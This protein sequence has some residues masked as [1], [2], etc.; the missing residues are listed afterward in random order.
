M[1]DALCLPIVTLN[2]DR[3]YNLFKINLKKGCLG[4]ALSSDI[5]VIEAFELPLKEEPKKKYCH[6]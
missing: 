1:S 6:L 4:L 3:F 2:N 5:L